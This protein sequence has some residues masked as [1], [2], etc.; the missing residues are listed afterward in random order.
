MCRYIDEQIGKEDVLDKLREGREATIGYYG[1]PITEIDD[2]VEVEGEFCLSKVT[3]KRQY[4]PFIMC[5]ACCS[6][7]PMS[8]M[9][10]D[11]I[12]VRIVLRHVYMY[13]SLMRACLP[14]GKACRATCESCERT[15]EYSND[16]FLTH[17][18]DVYACECCLASSPFRPRQ[19]D[20]QKGLVISI[21]RQL[22]HDL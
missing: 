6:M 22:G 12:A 4:T 17:S 3:F 1:Y 10:K 7:T 18:R 5:I 9:M 21:E 15:R 16:S 20:E 8:F 14:K 2:K 19:V 13:T 11:K